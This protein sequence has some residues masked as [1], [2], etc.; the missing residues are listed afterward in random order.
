MS[1][2]ITREFYEDEVI[3]DEGARGDVAYILMRGSVEIWTRVDRKKVVLD[4]LKP[5]S[6][7]GEMALIDE[8]RKR[9]ASARALTRS[10]VVEITKNTFNQYLKS[11]PRFIGAVLTTLVWRLKKTTEKASRIPDIFMSICE[12]LNLMALH[13]QAQLRY[14]ETAHAIARALF[15]DVSKV[16]EKLD[17]LETLSLVELKRL[18]GQEEPVAIAMISTDHFLLEARKAFQKYSR[19]SLGD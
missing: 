13:D 5:V 7:F 16:K 8:G 9:S 6:V 18:E 12:V 11:C 14:T 4:V 17:L 15:T 10:E 1:D 3:F 2:F 19:L